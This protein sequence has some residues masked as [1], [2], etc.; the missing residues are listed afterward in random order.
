MSS[1]RGWP[2]GTY[3]F[4]SYDNIANKNIDYIVH[5]VAVIGAVVSYMS[6]QP[7]RIFSWQILRQKEDANNSR[8][9]FLGG[10]PSCANEASLHKAF[11]QAFGPVSHPYT[12]IYATYIWTCIDWY[13]S[14][15]FSYYLEC[16]TML[17]LNILHKH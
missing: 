6:H 2:E 7:F 8:K 3:L 9:V 11:E 5:Y 15:Q 13:S 4:K 10:L 17:Y 12:F 16:N 1:Y 14:F